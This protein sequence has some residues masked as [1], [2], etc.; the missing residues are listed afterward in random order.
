MIWWTTFLERTLAHPIRLN[1]RVE[2]SS[3]PQRFEAT[4]VIICCFFF[5]NSAEIIETKFYSNAQKHT[6]PPGPGTESG[7]DILGYIQWNQ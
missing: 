6:R 5:L 1:S 3:D 2:Y 7:D 4:I